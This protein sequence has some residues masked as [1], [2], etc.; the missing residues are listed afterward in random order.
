MLCDAMRCYAMLWEVDPRGAPVAGLSRMV[1]DGQRW[2]A[3][4]PNFD[5]A[6]ARARADN[7]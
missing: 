6:T 2:M 7:C 3:R 4:G 1:L 5:F